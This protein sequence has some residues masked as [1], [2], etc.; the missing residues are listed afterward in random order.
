MPRLFFEHI[1]GLGDPSVHVVVRHY[2]VI[3]HCHP[4]SI[5]VNVGGPHLEESVPFEQVLIVDDEFPEAFAISIV[6]V[7]ANHLLDGI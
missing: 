7:L 1:M 6:S 3:V 2:G 4:K 5:L